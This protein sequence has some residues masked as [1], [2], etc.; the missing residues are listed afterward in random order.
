LIREAMAERDGFISQNEGA[1]I[2]RQR[3][4]GFNKKTRN[5]FG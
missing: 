2:V 5:G 4:H 3:W 1:N